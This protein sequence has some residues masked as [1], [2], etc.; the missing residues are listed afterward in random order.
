MLK[1]SR[2]GDD[3]G[4]NVQ[5]TAKAHSRLDE[6][7]KFDRFLKWSWLQLLSHPVSF[8][9]LGFPIG[10]FS[11]VFRGTGIVEIREEN[12]VTKPKTD[13]RVALQVAQGRRISPFDGKYASSIV[14][15]A[16]EFYGTTQ[17]DLKLM[18]N[19]NDIPLQNSVM[20]TH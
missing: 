2:H 4:P 11:N 16:N 14:L 7:S 15:L 8:V 1:K 18:K 6:A 17:G 5:T 20:G 3:V 12:L 13:L 9:R 10:Y 19:G